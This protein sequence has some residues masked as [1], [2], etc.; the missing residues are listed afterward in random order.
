MIWEEITNRCIYISSVNFF[1]DKRARRIIPARNSG[2]IELA[3]NELRR[4]LTFDE[5]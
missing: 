4:V 2:C 3:K 5:Q 1:A